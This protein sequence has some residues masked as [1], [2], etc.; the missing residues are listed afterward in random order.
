MYFVIAS[1]TSNETQ[2]TPSSSIPPPDIGLPIPAPSDSYLE[3]TAPKGWNTFKTGESI[4]LMV[5]NI[6][7]KQI[8]VDQDFGARIFVFKNDSW[9]EIGNKG[10]YADGPVIILEPNK[11]FSPEKIGAA[12]VLPDISVSSYLKIFILGSVFENEKKTED[13]VS[14]IDIELTP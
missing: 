3:L 6:S 2:I 7:D 1:C 4:T 14:Y 5:N 10:I 9:V 11:D 8:V 13:V 12:F